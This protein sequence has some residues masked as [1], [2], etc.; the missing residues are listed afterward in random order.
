ME[1]VESA[2]ARRRPGLAISDAGVEPSSAVATSGN[3]RSDT[4]H[5]KISA[6]VTSESA[7]QRRANA[8]WVGTG[9]KLYTWPDGPTWADSL[10][11][12]SPQNA[13]QSNTTS[14]GA[15]PTNTPCRRK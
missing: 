3:V 1:T 6:L 7:K 2:G 12:V 11:A 13:P 4:P 8:T 5:G 10:M 14:P 9:S 15:G